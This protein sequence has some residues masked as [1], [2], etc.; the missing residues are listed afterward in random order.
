MGSNLKPISVDGIMKPARVKRSE[1]WASKSDGT[2]FGFAGPSLGD[3]DILPPAI[4]RSAIDVK[5]TSY[6]F[7]GDAEVMFQP[8]DDRATIQNA[9][10]GHFK[11]R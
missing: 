10:L 4:D 1:D 9:S 3:A 6:R 7:R 5:R 11:L 2:P 8:L